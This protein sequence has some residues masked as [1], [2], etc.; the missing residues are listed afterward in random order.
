M[1]RAARKRQNIYKIAG[2]TGVSIATISRVINNRP[3]V[4]SDTRR[5]VLECIEDYRFV[6]RV[7]K[8]RVPNIG[9]LLEGSDAPISGYVAEVVNGITEAARGLGMRLSIASFATENPRTSSVLSHLR[10]MNMDGVAILMASDRSM[11]LRE[12]NEE[13]FPHVVIND[14]FDGTPNWIDIDN[15]KGVALAAAH[16]A[17]LGH[18][19]VAYLGGD[20]DRDNFRQRRKAYRA[21]VARHGFVD[22]ARLERSPEPNRLPHLDEGYRQARELLDQGIAFTA[23]ICSTDEFAFGAIMALR[24]RGLDIP[25]DVSVVGFDDC[26]I[27]RYFQP[28]LTTIHQPLREMGR[29]AAQEIARLIGLSR[30]GALDAA[31]FR[32]HRVVE[33]RLV[34]RNS[35]AGAARHEKSRRRK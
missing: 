28:A 5:R 3:N 32:F 35:T 33:P 21:A 15:Q 23:M 10:D 30:Q 16:L 24:E 7:Y 18:R 9:I 27:A 13:R 12:L 25:K 11:Y 6:P 31:S 34:I 22:D 20:P 8:N 26:E 17:D 4:A 19:R 14:R 1:I 2:R 29:I